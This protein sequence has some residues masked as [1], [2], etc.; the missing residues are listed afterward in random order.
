MKPQIEG[1]QPRQ[2]GQNRNRQEAAP[3]VDP[4]EQGER[5]EGDAGPGRLPRRDSAHPGGNNARREGEER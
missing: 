3:A 1:T 5:G 2:D 4:A